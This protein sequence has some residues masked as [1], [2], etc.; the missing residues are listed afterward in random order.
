VL[1]LRADRYEHQPYGLFGGQPAACSRNAMQVDG[2]W[3]T[4]PAKLTLEIGRDTVIR[5]EQAGG[6]GFGPPAER[7]PAA[8]RA[9]LRN[10]K[11]TAARAFADYGFRED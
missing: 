11:I 6:G 4:L 3:R 7:D 2:Q 9:D 10:G 5:H 1:Q 8:I